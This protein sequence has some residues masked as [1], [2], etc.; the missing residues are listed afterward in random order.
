MQVNCPLKEIRKSRTI[1]KIIPALGSIVRDQEVIYTQNPYSPP[2]YHEEDIH[3]NA[4]FY[5]I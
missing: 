3:F 1:I 4:V 2:N 5:V